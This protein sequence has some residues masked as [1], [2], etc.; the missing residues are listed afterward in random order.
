MQSK[1]TARIIIFR[2][3]GVLPHAD[4]H[5]DA[6]AVIA[7]AVIADAD[8]P[9]HA[10]VLCVECVEVWVM[11]CASFVPCCNCFAFNVMRGNCDTE[12]SE[13]WSGG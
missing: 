12:L 10:G 1:V 5:T 7:D 8:A 4:V 6:N 11:E 13:D 9:P 2:G 3:G